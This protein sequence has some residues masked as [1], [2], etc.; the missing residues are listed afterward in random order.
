MQPIKSILLTFDVEDWFQVEN[1]KK[2][3]PFSSWPDRELR[4]ESNTRRLLD[5]LDGMSHNSLKGTQSETAP[6]ATFFVLGWVAKRMPKLVR[7]IHACG[8]EIAS[9]GFNHNLC[10]DC[11]PA[12]LCE[13]LSESRKLLEDITGGSV[14]GYRAPG[15]SISEDVLKMVEECGYSYDSSYNSFSGNSRYGKL[16]LVRNGAGIASRIS[17]SFFE[18][19]VSNMHLGNTVIP[20]GGGGYFRLV[21]APFFRRAVRRVLDRDNAYLFYLHPW[22]I[23]PDQP[24]VEQASLFFKFRHY[25]NLN[26]TLPRFA[27]LLKSL[28]GCRFMGCH[29]Y[30]EQVCK[31][32]FRAKTN[33]GI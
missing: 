8:H 16:D 22:E 2:H 15:F 14:Y 10:C 12:Q 6:K 23:D 17:S 27:G 9:H 21:P 13:D 3:I 31:N 32:E 28:A 30:I 7:D 4:V 18:L 11:T 1:F 24:R 33:L 5:V 29:D 25:V 26:K 20:I 19:P